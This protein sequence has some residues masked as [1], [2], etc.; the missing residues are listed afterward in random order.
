MKLDACL[1]LTPAQFSRLEAGV[2]SV[3]SDSVASHSVFRILCSVFCL[4]ILC[5]VFCVLYSEMS[6]IVIVGG[7]H[8]GLVALTTSREPATS[9]SSSSAGAWSAAAPSPARSGR[10]TAVRRWRIRSDR[11]VPRWSATCSWHGGSSLSKAIRDWSRSR[12]TACRSGCFA[13]TRGRSKPSAR[14]RNLTPRSIRPSARRS[15]SSADSSRRCWRSRPRRSTI[16][17]RVSSGIC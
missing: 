3:F 8:N 17:R 9:R 4:R 7:G 13:I 14:S 2:S 16:L 12:A 1:V 6:R 10:A 5:S 15:R 11:S